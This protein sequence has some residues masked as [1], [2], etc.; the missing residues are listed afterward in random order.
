MA[1]EAEDDDLHADIRAALEGAG[2][3]AESAAPPPVEAEAP[4]GEPTETAAE[5]EAR[6]RDEKGRFAKPG[7]AE[8]AAV[9]VAPGAEPQQPQPGDAAITPPVSWK[10]AAKAKW[11]SIDPDLREEISRRERE[12]IEGLAQRD[13]QVGDYNR[14]DAL[15]APVDQRLALA[16]SNRENY[17]RG[18][19][20]ADEMLRGPNREQA[21]V[22]LAQ[23]YRIPLPN[24]QPQPQQQQVDPQVQAQ[25][26]EQMVQTAL[27]RH[28]AESR[29]EETKT[30]IAAFASD[31]AHL[32]FEN[33]KPVMIG[34]LNSGAAESLKQAYDMACNADP[35]IR[36]LLTPAAQPNKQPPATRQAGLSLTGSPPVGGGLAAPNGSSGGSIEDDI[37]AAM[38]EH[39]ARV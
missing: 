5:A 6:T 34:L 25:H 14:L 27:Q 20:T 33:V 26:V 19:I 29:N 16:G 10:A 9:Q 32:Y 17:L 8:Q 1:F 24:G 7:D 11:A 30:E 4:A 15:F 37:R 12:I 3:P 2:E 23:M 39:G 36:A 21:I 35:N 28:V 31:P 13:R 22:Q 38:Q 18:L